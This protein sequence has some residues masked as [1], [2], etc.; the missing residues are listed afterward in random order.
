[1]ENKTNHLCY[2]CGIPAE[3]QL[4]NKKWCCM[5]FSQQCPANREKRSKILKE[6]WNRLKS[7]GYKT[8]YLSELKENRYKFNR[9]KPYNIRKVDYLKSQLEEHPEECFCKYCGKPAKYVLKSGTFC[10]SPSY[11]SCPKIIE[12]NRKRCLDRLDKLSEKG[13]KRSFY[14]Y[15]DLPEETKEKMKIIKKGDTIEN[16]D[17]IRK[18]HQTRMKKIEEGT[19][20]PWNRGV[21][22]SES[23]KESIRKGTIRYLEK[24]GALERQESHRISQKGI[25]YMD[26]LNKT[27]GWNLQHGGNGG[28]YQVAG[29]FLDGYDSEKNIAFEYD[30]KKHYK[31][32]EENILKD[33]DIKRQEIIIE[34]LGCQF[35]R[36][37]EKKNYFYKVN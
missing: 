6:R 26:N 18:S 3:Y 34:K 12:L 5:P 23:H 29:Y 28:E 37:N 17:I 27:F 7:C 30:E 24:T 14:S 33:K 25:A 1:M 20:I 21:P 10:C 8:Q 32:W 15:Q 4:K 11:N 19:L 13:L 9:E 16:N 2:Y 22:M 35:Y 36:Y 31:N